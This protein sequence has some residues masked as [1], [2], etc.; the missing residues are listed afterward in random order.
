MDQAAETAAMVAL[1]RDGRRP[2]QLYADLVEDAGSAL[3]VLDQESE[4]D[5]AQASLFPTETAS[6]LDAARHEIAG[7]RGIELLTILHPAYPKNLRAV[8]DRPP[9]I[10]VAGRLEPADARSVAV[11]GARAASPAGAAAAAEIA[12]HL[13][14][15]DYTVTS[16]LAAG[17]D[18]AAHTAALKAGGRTVAVIGTG[19]NRAYPPENAALQRRIATECAVVSQFWPDSPPSQRSFPMRNAVMSGISLATV[20]I[21]AS[22]TSGARVQARL[23]LAHG[24]PVFMLE[25]L[26]A[27]QAW[28][29]EFSERPGVQIARRTEDLITGLGRLTSAGA[30]MR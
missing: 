15:S 23:A 22:S 17:I 16:G 6:L 7:W 4:L 14:R 11:I 12:T 3:A 8:H 29:R 1:L 20:I 10:F 9:L 21:E 5:G 24:R 27:T 25:S 18:T 28:A 19:L 13:V 2:W 26:V 30:L